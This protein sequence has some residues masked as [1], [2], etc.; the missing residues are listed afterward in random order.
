MTDAMR[1]TLERA[2]MTVC[3][4]IND[5]VDEVDKKGG[6]VRDHMTIDGLKDCVKT[7]KD[8]MKIRMMDSG[9][10]APKQASATVTTVK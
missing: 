9:N 5:L 6:H 1:A 2:E 3:N 10:A 7:L 4:H 8:I